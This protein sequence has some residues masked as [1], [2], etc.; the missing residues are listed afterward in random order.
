MFCSKIGSECPH[1]ILT[2]DNLVFVLM[3]F[4]GFDNVYDAMERAVKGIKGKNYICERA[5][6]KYTNKQIWCN[7]IC[8]RIRAAKY[9]IADTS[10]KNP[11]VFY[12]LGFTHAL[13]NTEAI[14]IT[15][16]IDEAP[17]DIK[18]VGHVIYDKN[19]LGKLEEDLIEIIH[20]MDNE[21]DDGGISTKSPDEQI[22]SLKKQV[23]EE[24]ERVEK[25]KKRYKESEESEENFKTALKELEAIKENPP[26]KAIM[27]I[28]ELEGN[29]AELKSK[30]KYTEKDR[31]DKIDGLS[32]KLEEKEENL[33]AIEAQ[34][35]DS[36]E[37]GDTELLSRV[38]GDESIK[39]ISSNEWNNRGFA[40][41]ES[42]RYEE[43]I[44]S[45]DKAIEFKPDNHG[46]WE[47]RGFVLSKLKRYEEAIASYDK[48]IELK[49]YNHKAW[50]NK[51]LA[52]SK[53]KRYE[54]A[55]TSNDKAIELKRDKHEAWYNRG[56]ALSKLKRYEE[57]IASYDKSIEFKPDKQE[58]WYN[59]ACTHSLTK[60]KEKMLKNLAKAI[61]LDDK[62]KAMAQR[63]E[64]FNAYWDDLD[65][66]D[67]T[68][69]KY[70]KRIS[71]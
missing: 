53:L 60:N 24:E 34:L 31:T 36:K 12:E 45:Y 71:N 28:T 41:D 33:K 25:F 64:D 56:Y 10:G 5:D 61:E 14:I 52:L 11:N 13:Y 65:F 37:K 69:S 57:A 54:E 50:Y 63:D 17:F 48:T 40:L 18:D 44:A 4:E 30:L 16:N 55:I 38:L 47:N 43:A 23:R 22:A 19:K 35:K 9:I 2:N 6:T 51:G 1:K 46:A 39:M 32:K 70:D 59:K 26:E 66:I 20:D 27:K 42:K 49:P 7:R 62:Y 21:K 68:K 67:L 8:K 3:P 29:I 15:Q 58:A